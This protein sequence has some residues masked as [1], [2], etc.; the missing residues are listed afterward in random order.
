MSIVLVG[1]LVT[2]AAALSLNAHLSADGAI[3]AAV[4]PPYN[5][6]IGLSVDEPPSVLRLHIGVQYPRILGYS[7]AHSYFDD[8]YERIH[9]TPSVL[10]LGNISN[11]QQRTINVWSA[12][13]D[14]TQT[15]SAVVATGVDGIT[16]I[17]PDPL[18]LVFMPLEQ[19]VWEINV[20]LSGP[21]VVSAELVWEFTDL[22]DRATKITGNRIVAWVWSPNWDTP[23]IERD[24][25]LTDILRANSG[26][27]QRIALRL[28]PRRSWEF[29]LLVTGAAR[30]WLEAALFDWGARV[31]A[32]PV[33]TDVVRLPGAVELGDVQLPVSSANRDYTAGGLVLLRISA[34][35][36]EI[37]E[38]S[39][40]GAVLGLSNGL[41]AAWPAGTYVYPMRMA[42]LVSQIVGRSSTADVLAAKAQFLDNEA[43]AWPA[44]EP[45]NTYRAVPVLEIEP[46]YTNP[47]AQHVERLLHTLD[48]QIS[49]ADVVDSAG[50]GYPALDYCIRL[51]TPAARASWRSITY[52]IRGAQ[53][54][55]WV[56]TWKLD[57]FVVAPFVD[58]A[59]SLQV[60]ESGLVRYIKQQPGRRDVR[61]EMRDGTI[62]YRR[63]IG[64]EFAS[65]GVERITLDAPIGITGT[66]YDIRRV[67]WLVPC[68]LEAD[69][70]EYTH[71]TAHVSH[72]QVTFRAV[73]DDV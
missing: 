64:A 43:V 23:V 15:L 29:S 61:I 21:P 37:A 20:G 33:W 58:T 4:V 14:R 51:D 60:T 39:T 53:G 46:L 67:S 62:L 38:V 52:A 3:I 44:V 8:F 22:L 13:I 12:Y 18:P 41:R 54:V 34:T 31:W 50:I 66:A 10:A 32:L 19:F 28:T 71:I 48:N 5:E 24:V 69:A 42:R 55:L 45:V 9:I 73:P 68:R 35:R 6:S 70:V 30:Q 17:A 63:V 25:W 40:L 26:A 16:V 47:R 11:V 27:E 56:P 59:V 7:K 57:I 1:L 65:D 72:V 49:Q 2:S 36:Y